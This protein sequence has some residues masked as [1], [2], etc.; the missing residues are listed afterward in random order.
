[1]KHLQS[2]AQ[3]ETEPCGDT[4]TEDRLRARVCDIGDRLRT[5]LAAVAAALPGAPT[6]PLELSKALR[7]NQVLAGKVL[8]AIRKHDPLLSTHLMPG[9]EALRTLLRGATAARVGRALIEP[10][11]TAVD[12]FDDLLRRV[13]GG[14]SE[15]DA[16]IGAWLPEARRRFES[17]AKQA[18]FRAMCSIK[19]LTADLLLTTSIAHP[20]VDGHVDGATL[21]GALG[22]RRIRPGVPVGLTNELVGQHGD[23]GPRWESLDGT[24]IGNTF[25]KLLLREFTTPPGTTIETRQVG[26]RV[27]Y[28]LDGDRLGL[29]STANLFLADMLRNGMPLKSEPDSPRVFATACIVGIPARTVVMDMLVH[30]SVWTD[31]ALSLGVYETAVHGSCDVNS[32][33]SE[34]ARLHLEEN[35][36]YLGEGIE[37]F[38]SGDVPLYLELLQH[39]FN[40]LGWR[41]SEFRGYRVCVSYPVYGSQICLEFHPPGKPGTIAAYAG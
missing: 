9:P 17:S 37:N 3:A 18:A 35:V 5:S 2:L 15:L 39:A 21:Q 40:Q 7:V 29:G 30:R 11:E 12:A 10:A 27:R 6:R 1:M 16:A 24:P 19:G 25:A 23:R 22:L 36:Q 20:S 32:P 34:L 41:A 13:V 28:L 4:C 26:D 31:R 14:R 8:Q 38:R 33:D